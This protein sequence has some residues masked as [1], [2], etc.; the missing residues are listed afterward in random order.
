MEPSTPREAIDRV[1]QLSMLVASDLARYERE[2]GL[3]A[4]RIHL[5]WELGRGGPQTQQRLAAAMDV[6][7]RNVTGLVD[8]LVASGHVTREPHPSDR[9]ATLVTPTAAG[10]AVIEENEAGYDDLAR[11]L[12]GDLPPR[13]LATFCAVL[14]ETIARFTA[15]ME[16]AAP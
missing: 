1:M 14:D 6:T 8:G 5:L 7:P 9:R 4:A 10:R 11:Q 2:S 15:L 13:R 12:F 16:E 3:T